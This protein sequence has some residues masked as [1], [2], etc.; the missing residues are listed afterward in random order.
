MSTMTFFKALF[1]ASH[2]LGPILTQKNL[3]IVNPRCFLGLPQLFH[4]AKMQKNKL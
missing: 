4:V 2:I 3:L 1:M